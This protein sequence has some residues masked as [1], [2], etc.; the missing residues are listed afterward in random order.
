MRRRGC[1]TAARAVAPF[2][3]AQETLALRKVGVV[4]RSG[5]SAQ[6]NVARWSSVFD[7]T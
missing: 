6:K 2:R 5:A 7:R 4:V 1:R 3:L